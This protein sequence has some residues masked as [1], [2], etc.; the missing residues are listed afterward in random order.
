M[1]LSTSI[2]RRR[3]R[4]GEMPTAAAA[5]R[6]HCLECCGGNGV[7]VRECTGAECWLYPWRFGQ[8]P[9][10]AARAG[11]VVDMVYASRERQHTGA[12]FSCG[13]SDSAQVVSVQKGECDA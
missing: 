3:R 6:N 11:E 7:D 2:H 8:R 12:G 1:G 13:A 9:D 5:I 10:T 4:R